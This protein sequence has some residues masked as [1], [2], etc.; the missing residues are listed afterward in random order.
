MPTFTLFDQQTY[1]TSTADGIT[2]NVANRFTVDTA[3]T[4][5]ACWYY[6]VTGRTAL[7]ST[8]QLWQVTGASATATGTLLGSA[9][10]TWSGDAG[11]GW[12]RAP[13]DTPTPVEAGNYAVAAYRAGGNWLVLLPHPFWTTGAGAGGFHN[14]PIATLGDGGLSG[15]NPSWFANSNVFPNFSRGGTNAGQGDAVDVEVQTQAAPLE[16]T[17]TS[18]PAA[19][20]GQTYTATLAAEGGTSPYTWSVT[21]G[22]LPA[23][24]TLN[25]STGVISGTPT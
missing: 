21:A 23:G 10:P 4:V 7:P 1:T 25:S 24:L 17:T 9:T 6:S 15:V 16:V 12:V 2:M 22:S 19:T 3:A 5:T 13:F 11:S 20:V 8:I 18:L 14:G